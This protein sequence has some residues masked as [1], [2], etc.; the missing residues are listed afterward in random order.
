MLRACLLA[1]GLLSLVQHATAQPTPVP[2]PNILW[3][4]CEDTSPDLGCYGDA[5]AVT[6]NLDKLASAGARF[7][8]CFTHAGVCAPSRSGIITGMYPTSIGTHHMRCKGVPP[9]YVKC[10]TEY[11]RAAGYYCTNNVKTDYQFDAPLTAWDESSNQAHWRGR[12]PGQPFFSVFNF[13]VTHESQI[14]STEKQFAENTKRLR[15]EDRH[16]PAK[17]TLPPYYPDTPV[18]RRD[19][20][21][22]Y[23]LV[24]AMDLKVADLLQQ[25]AD[26][27][28]AD[29]TIVF[30]Y[31]DHGRG[32]PR[33]KR[34]IYDSGIHVPL[35]IRWPGKIQPGTVR[36]DLVAFVDLAPTLLSIA[37]VEIPKHFQ[38]QAF[39]GPQQAPPR[40]Y[41]YAARDRMDERYDMIRAVRDQRYKYI[42]NYNTRKPYA[43][44]IA[45]MDEMPTMQE[46]RRLAAAKKLDGPQA[47]FFQPPR[48]FEELY[49]V[50]TDPHEIDNLAKNP[51]FEEVLNQMR[52]AH[53]DWTVQT[54]DLGF[55]P[56]PILDEF[57]RPG[58]TWQTTA[59]P[60]IK[61]K[62]EAGLTEITCDTKGASIAY[63]TNDQK[64]LRWKIYT[65]PTPDSVLKA[66]SCRLGFKD[67][68]IAT[69]GSK[70]QLIPVDQ[71]EPDPDL[72]LARLKN[73][74]IPALRA[75]PLARGILLM[76]AYDDEPAVR[77]A[78]MR[79]MVLMGPSADL[80]T[81]RDGLRDVSPIVRLGA[82]EALCDLAEPRDAVPVLAALTTHHSASLRLHALLALDDIG[83]HAQP[84]IPALRAIVERKEKTEYDTRVAEGILKR[85]NSK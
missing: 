6:P 47:L 21:R 78:A 30:F 31:G 46:W 67:S 32:L 72:V 5:Y 36:D 74:L 75:I 11:L 8:H 63:L 40:Q 28:L 26:D 14:C 85:L 25:L 55:L 1:F 10:F 57:M 20:A 12:E 45:Y 52:R 42:R 58:G 71:N 17:A 59:A 43:Q 73:E 80:S 54:G 37:G 3:I 84:A 79:K 69:P 4:T 68:E 64:P 60:T 66:C 70:A 39:L 44:H 2:R 51:E 81:V 35:L 77:Y 33:G 7:T 27:G 82:A 9:S 53:T 38:G 19:W 61:A 24:T 76:K 16:D 50:T 83:E 18:V 15:P 49:D 65:K 48:P 56:E 22:Y 34:W 13:T 41:I 62:T 29:N 23:D